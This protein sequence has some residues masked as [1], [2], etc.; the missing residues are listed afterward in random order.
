MKK[1]KRKK[2]FLHC[3]PVGELLKGLAIEG[4]GHPSVG[5]KGELHAVLDLWL[6]ALLHRGVRIIFVSKCIGDKLS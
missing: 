2:A 4:D 5:I 3:H 1:K 6:S